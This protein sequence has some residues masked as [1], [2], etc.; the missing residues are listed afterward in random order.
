MLRVASGLTTTFGGEMAPLLQIDRLKLSL[1]ATMEQLA[2]ASP[3]PTKYGLAL[4]TACFMTIGLISPILVLFSVKRCLSAMNQ[5]LNSVPIFL[6]QIA[7]TFF[8][9]PL[10]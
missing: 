4:K 8:T 1:T 5:S 3:P 10:A 7:S 6:K 2:S 9:K